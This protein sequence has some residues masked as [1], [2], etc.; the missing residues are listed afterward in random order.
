MRAHAAELRIDP[1]KIYLL[2]NSAG[3]M[4]GLENIYG[5]KKSDY[6]SYIEDEE[7]GYVNMGEL[8]EYCEKG[9]D[10]V[11]NGVV[12]LWGAVHDKNI[13][14]NSKVPVFLAHGDSDYVM[15]FA[16]GHA[17]SDGYPW[18]KCCICSV[19]LEG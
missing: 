19:W 10:G 15:P 9:F 13:V 11:A 8:D 3:G 4:M 6:P 2:G 16:E 1:D 5:Q 7:K 12:A 17:V 18:P 14:N